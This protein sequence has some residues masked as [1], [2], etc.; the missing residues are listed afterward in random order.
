MLSLTQ[1]VKPN[2]NLDTV[3]IFLKKNIR[4][5]VFFYIDCVAPFEFKKRGSF[6]SGQ[7]N[8]CFSLVKAPYLINYS[9]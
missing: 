3:K 5:S 1:P 9:D 2:D 8:K 4:M 7:F 6:V